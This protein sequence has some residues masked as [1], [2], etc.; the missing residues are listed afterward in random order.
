[1]WHSNL[2]LLAL[3]NLLKCLELS[4]S[5]TSREYGAPAADECSAFAALE[6]C[7]PAAGEFSFPSGGESG[8]LTAGKI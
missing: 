1:M 3:V 5:Q 4:G 7:A 2:E 6:Y 8:A